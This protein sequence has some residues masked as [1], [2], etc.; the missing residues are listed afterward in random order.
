MSNRSSPTLTSGACLVPTG[1]RLSLDVVCLVLWQ[2]TEL[3][4]TAILTGKTVAMPVRVVSVEENST[5]RDISE[6]VE[7]KAMDEDVIKV[8]GPPGSVPAFQILGKY[9]Q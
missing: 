7:C 9:L 4:N 5:V 1:W 6:L 8:R 2:D 3:L